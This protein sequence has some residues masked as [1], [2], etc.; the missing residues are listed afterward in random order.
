MN[1]GSG[2]IHAAHRE[3]EETAQTGEMLISLRGRLKPGLAETILWW[4]RKSSFVTSS[5]Y[6]SMADIAR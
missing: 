5:Y 2:F 3:A 6:R 4:R 1:G